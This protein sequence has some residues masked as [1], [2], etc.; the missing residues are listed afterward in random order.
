M[1]QELYQPP[2]SLVPRGLRL[3]S[4]V[5]LLLD[6][7]CFVDRLLPAQQ[8]PWQQLGDGMWLL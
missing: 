7:H 3:V 8:L 6:Q 5:W 4:K 2:V 1:E